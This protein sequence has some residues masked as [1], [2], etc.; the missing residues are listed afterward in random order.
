MEMYLSSRVLHSSPASLDTRGSVLLSFTTQAQ[1][2][3]MRE[4]GCCTYRRVFSFTCAILVDG[5]LLRVMT[6]PSRY[7]RTDKGRTK[8]AN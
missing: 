6:G 7:A 1:E 4:D 2:R 8:K 3:E 5:H